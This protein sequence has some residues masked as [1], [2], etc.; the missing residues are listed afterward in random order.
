LPEEYSAVTFF[1]VPHGFR[2]GDDIQKNFLAIH[3]N[4]NIGCIWIKLF[5]EINFSL[6]LIKDVFFK[7][8][9]VIDACHC[10]AT[11]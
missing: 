2:G 3:S 7:R 6:I 11:G 1:D 8:R 9:L 10:E 5:I 4:N